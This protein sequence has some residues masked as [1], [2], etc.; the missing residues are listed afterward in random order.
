MV[1][2]TVYIMLTKRVGIF[3]K[4]CLFLRKFSTTCINNESIHDHNRWENLIEFSEFLTKSVIYNSDGLVILSKPYGVPLAPASGQKRAIL[5]PKQY[6]LTESLPYLAKSL[7]YERLIVVKTPER[8]TSGI[9]V[10]SPCEKVAEKVRTC[11]LKGNAREQ[12]CSHYLAVVLGCP[13]PPSASVKIG[14]TLEKHPVQNNDKKPVVLYKWS[15]TSVK[16]GLVKVIRVEHNT[17]YS[18]DLASLVEISPSAT[19]WHFIRVYLAQLLS[20]VLGDHLYGNRV[21]YIMNTFLPV[22]HFSD[23]A[24]GPQRIHPE[25]KTILSIEPGQE[26]LIPTHLH[27]HKLV[28]P[29]YTTKNKDFIIEVAPPDSF[30][31]TCHLLKLL[32]PTDD[33]SSRVRMVKNC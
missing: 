23:S 16:R 6:S 12:F 30:Q 24:K 7:G 17:L 28:I 32:E 21:H 11:L 8:Y 3:V 4:R 13:Q 20:P 18:Q 31:R 25:L 33:T 2:I 22:N 29:R 15:T 14:L 10:L 5:T 19:K 27:L 9:T 1:I 26:K